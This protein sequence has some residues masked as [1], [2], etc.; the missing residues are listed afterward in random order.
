MIQLSY[1]VL[2]RLST[3]DGSDQFKRV[4]DLLQTCGYDGV[5]LN[6]TEPLGIDPDKLLR[7]V[8]DA[9]LSVPSFLTGEAYSDGLCLSSPDA[10]VRARTVER[11][12]GYVDVVRPFD[13][14]LVVGLLQGQ[15]RDESDPAVANERIVDCLKSVAE[16]AGGKGVEIVIEP[17]NHLQVGFNH[18]V[19]EVRSLIAAIGSTAVRP[20][21]DTIH[22][23]IEERSLTQPIL[24]CGRSLRHVH[25]C[26]S[27][28]GEFGTG[29]V[30]FAAV[31]RALQETDYEGFA[32]VKVYRHADFETAARSSIEHLRRIGF[33]S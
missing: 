20:M 25:L 8:H 27:N 17:V 22:M 31:G 5:E 11:L 26:E 32:S 24:D 29:H 3:F 18:T 33:G 6:I 1:I 15:R 30:D 14:I 2:P 21:V 28:A 23:N 19:A 4:L 7:L 10:T 16:V 9:G 12:I 13:A